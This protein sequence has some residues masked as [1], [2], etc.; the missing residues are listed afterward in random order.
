ML[1]NKKWIYPGSFDSM[2]NGHLKTAEHMIATGIVEQ[3]TIWIGKNPDKANSSAFHH[4]ER[5]AM[6]KDALLDLP[7]QFAEKI[8]VDFVQWLLTD[9]CQK[10]WIKYILKTYRNPDD[11]RE[12]SAQAYYNSTINP[13]VETKLI[14]ANF[15]NSLPHVSSSAE[16]IL[17]KLQG[18]QDG[19]HSTLRI[20]H[21]LETRMNQQYIVGMTGEIWSGKSYVGEKFVQVWEKFGIP[22]HNIDFDSLWHNILKKSDDY[23]HVRD[24]IK[25]TFWEQCINADGSIH[26]WN[27]W[28][29]VFNPKNT[30]ELKKLNHIMK[31]P[32]QTELRT[33]LSGKTWLLIFN[34]ALL[35]EHDSGNLVNNN[36]VSINVDRL[37]QI[38]RLVGR[39]NNSVNLAKRDGKEFTTQDAE[40]RIKLKWDTQK[41]EAYFHQ[42][43][44]LK[45]FGSTVKFDNTSPSEQ[46]FTKAYLETL[47][48]VDTDLSLRFT[49]I[50]KKLG[51]TWNAQQL[52]K[53]TYFR[54]LNN[55]LPYHNW[56]HIKAW[57]NIIY[58]YRDDLNN[59]ELVAMARF[60]HDAIYN[61]M[62][63]VAWWKNNELLSAELA[64]STLIADGMAAHDAWKI[65]Q[66]ILATEHKTSYTH[67]IDQQ[68]LMDIDMSILASDKETYDKYAKAIR[69]EYAQYPDAIYNPGRIQLLEWFLEKPIF[70]SKAFTH[71]EAKAKANLKRE[72][73]SLKKN[74][75]L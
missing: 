66:L 71:L 7:K 50:Y 56:E 72:I 8:H 33:I 73:Y 67:D 60:F 65:R 30:E 53:D 68:Y 16:K 34:N 6:I 4:Q 15:D 47:N 27:L 48:T 39:E 64:Q 18:N 49:S 9:Y 74:I 70:H 61:T 24:E 40:D 58:Q 22:T 54:Y 41:K 13:D 51:L 17:T 21:A 19:I 26:R 23:Q 37:E 10:K 2:H 62:P 25:N 35:A 75:A 38:K 28:G 46:D 32:L 43:Q 42:V 59:P 44:R 20:K 29:I 3:L 12:E 14:Q 57:I 11:F 55:E 63:P 52:F 69:M 36:V 5:A 45:R 31:E 1:D